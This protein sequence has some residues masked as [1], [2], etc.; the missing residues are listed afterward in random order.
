MQLTFGDAESLGK[1]KQ[2]RRE[3]FLSDMEKVVPWQQLLA[4][5]VVFRDEGTHWCG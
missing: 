4:L 5:S 2:T 3:I 1:R